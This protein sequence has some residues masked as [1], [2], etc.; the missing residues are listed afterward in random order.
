M[1]VATESNYRTTVCAKK[2]I[3]Y[4]FNTAF[5]AGSVMGFAVVSIAL[6]G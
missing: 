1:Y 2:S 6:G 3:G 5:K 4:A